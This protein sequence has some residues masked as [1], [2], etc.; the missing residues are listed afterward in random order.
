MQQKADS[1]RKVDKHRRPLDCEEM[2]MKCPKCSA[3]TPDGEPTCAS[4]GTELK[5]RARDDTLVFPCPYCGTEN[6]DTVTECMSCHK[7]I[8]SPFIYCTNC[9]KRNL[10]TDGFCT[11]C[12]IPLPVPEKPARKPEGPP[13][14]ESA[15]CPSCGNPMER[16]FVIAPSEG[17]FRGI[18]WSGYESPLWLYAGEP[19]QLG[20]LVVSNMNI[21][22][23][24]CPA[25]KL[26]VMRY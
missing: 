12:D 16:G 25:C 3:D 22:S 11:Q 4:C 7:Q 6:Y 5:P 14:P 10:A 26:V 21:P 15:A 19:L 8:R 2:A 24:R 1:R 20:N 17:A 9:G 18:R 13:L 23:F